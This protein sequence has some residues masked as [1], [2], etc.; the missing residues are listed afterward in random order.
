MSTRGSIHPARTL[1]AAK[2]RS[3]TVLGARAVADPIESGLHIVATPIG[4][5]GDISLRA[6]ATLAAADA[7]LAEDTRI[8]SRLTSLDRRA[9]TRSS[10]DRQNEQRHG[11]DHA[12][13]TCT[14]PGLESRWT[15]GHD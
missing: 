7:I 3:F 11:S 15:I 1:R 12:G 9:G 2:E 5:L 14:M 10:P 4:N 13:E 6:L 8:S